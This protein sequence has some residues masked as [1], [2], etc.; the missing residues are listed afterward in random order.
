MEIFLVFFMCAGC[1]HSR[2]FLENDDFDHYFKSLKVLS[3]I[4]FFS[5]WSFIINDNKQMMAY[6]S[7]SNPIMHI[8]KQCM[9]V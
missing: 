3:V 7:S 1:P 9:F 4:I 8:K 2:Y 5:K 6:M